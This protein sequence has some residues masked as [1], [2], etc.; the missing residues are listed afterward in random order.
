MTQKRK[1]TFAQV[2]LPKT[3]RASSAS[4]PKGVD[5]VCLCTYHTNTR[6]Y[7]TQ[8][9]LGYWTSLLVLFSTFQSP[10]ALPVNNIATK[11]GLLPEL[12]PQS[13]TK[14]KKGKTETSFNIDPK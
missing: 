7:A 2:R 11:I 5:Y 10:P 14:G 8:K 4:S 12:I 3:T 9:K 13:H 1:P 6:K